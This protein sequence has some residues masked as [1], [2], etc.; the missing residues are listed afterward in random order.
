[1]KKKLHAPLRRLAIQELSERSSS[2]DCSGV[3]IIQMTG[4]AGVDAHAETSLMRAENPWF[5]PQCKQFQKPLGFL[6]T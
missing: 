1:M 3:N 6:E 2:S 4:I 5:R